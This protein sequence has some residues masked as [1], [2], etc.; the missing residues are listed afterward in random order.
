[1][2]RGTRHK[3]RQKAGGDKSNNLAVD[4]RN[5]HSRSRGTTHNKRPKVKKSVTLMKPYK[6]K[7][8]GRKGSKALPQ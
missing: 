6:Q 8:G 2:L 1:L 3:A 4:G 7:R 5:G